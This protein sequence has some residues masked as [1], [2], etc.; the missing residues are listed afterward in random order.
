MAVGA[1]DCVVGAVDVLALGVTVL[2]IRAKDVLGME[3]TLSNIQNIA[4][5]GRAAEVTLAWANVRNKVPKKHPKRTKQCACDIAKFEVTENYSCT[6]NAG[7]RQGPGRPK[8]GEPNKIK[9]VCY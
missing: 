9:K 5:D 3:G 1:E 7:R 4:E 8:K 6:S 2:T